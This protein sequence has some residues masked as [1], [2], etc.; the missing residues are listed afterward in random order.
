MNNCFFYQPLG[1][2]AY[3]LCSKFYPQ[4]IM[5]MPV[6][7]FFTYLGVCAYLILIEK[8]NYSSFLNLI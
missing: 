4:N 7:K 5:Y 2:Y 6:V 1:V 3:L 8:S